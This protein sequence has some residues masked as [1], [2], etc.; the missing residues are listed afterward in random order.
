MI[1]IHEGFLQSVD[2][3]VLDAAYKLMEDYGVPEDSIQIYAP[4]Y[5]MG[6]YLEQNPLVGI[7]SN[8]VKK[9]NRWMGYNLFPGYENA[10]VVSFNDASLR[11]VEP[12]KIKIP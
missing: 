5:F 6:I 1:A 12:I 4:E 11:G 8:K 7:S 2:R 10:I 9:V 3:L